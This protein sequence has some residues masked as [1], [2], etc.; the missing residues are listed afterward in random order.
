MKIHIDIRNDIDIALALSRVQQV[1][2]EGR[3][4][5]NGKSYCWITNWSDGITVSTR[6]NRKS[7]CFVVFK[8]GEYGK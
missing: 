3:I 6:D 7:D 8:R 5:N 2:E 1:I 4:S